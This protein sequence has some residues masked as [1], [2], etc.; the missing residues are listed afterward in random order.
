MRYDFMP[1]MLGID[2]AIPLGLVLNELLTNAFKYAFR[3]RS[4]GVLEI[5][6]KSEHVG[7]P[8]LGARKVRML[9]R[10]DGVGLPEGL[11]LDSLKTLGLTMVRLLAERQLDGE[12]NLETGKTGTHIAVEFIIRD[13]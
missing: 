7:E 4:K 9:I 11:D 2:R 13:H 3:G 5:E 10:D 8:G 6:L 12:F 1:V